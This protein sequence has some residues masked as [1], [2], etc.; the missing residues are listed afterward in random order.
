MSADASEKTEAG[1]LLG[2]LRGRGASEE[3]EP[4]H[5]RLVTSNKKYR[6]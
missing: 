6:L 5:S 4:V 3:V 2:M 1:E